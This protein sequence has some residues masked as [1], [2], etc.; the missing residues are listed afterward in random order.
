MR[1]SRTG[2]RGWSLEPP[3]KRRKAREGEAAKATLVGT[4]QLVCI[5]SMRRPP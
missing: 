3:G 4:V 2:G 5:Q 1:R